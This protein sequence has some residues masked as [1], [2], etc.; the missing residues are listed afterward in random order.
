MRL[1]KRISHRFDRFAQPLE[2]FHRVEF[3]LLL[4]AIEILDDFSPKISRFLQF[5]QIDSVLVHQVND[6]VRGQGVPGLFGQTQAF[7]R[8]Q[9]VFENDLKEDVQR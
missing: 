8:G 5:R 1:S 4:F 3:A 7:R 9:F 2:I 6:E